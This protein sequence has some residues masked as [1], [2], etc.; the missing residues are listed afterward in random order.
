M[1]SSFF[2]HKPVLEEDAAQWIFASYAWALS[3]F[4]AAVFYD[5]TILVTPSNEHFFGRE[6]SVQGMANLIFERV[7]SYAGMQHWPVQLAGGE[8]CPQPEPAR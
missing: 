5:E 3:N 7:K 1:F 4:D 6:D 8:F 2:S